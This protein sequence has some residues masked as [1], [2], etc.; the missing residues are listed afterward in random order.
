MMR[1]S[2]VLPFWFPSCVPVPGLANP[3]P[4][5]ITPERTLIFQ[6]RTAR[7]L[8]HRKRV[9]VSSTQRDNDVP[10]PAPW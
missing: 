5:D 1:D 4:R 7:Q 2:T 9:L 3:G 8:R 10:P 6:V